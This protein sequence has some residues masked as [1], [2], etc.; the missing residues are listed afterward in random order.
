MANQL[1]WGFIGLQ[2]LFAQRLSTL[3]PRVIDDAITQSLAEWNRQVGALTDVLV[4]RTTEAQERFR[5]PGSGTLQPLDEHGVPIP[6]RVGAF[7]DVGFPIQGGGTAWG[8]NRVSRALMTVGE[9]NELQVMV[10]TQ[11]AD[12]MR[13]HM[14]AALLDNTSWAYSDPDLGAL[15]VHPLANND[16]QQYLLGTNLLTTDDHY[17]AQAAAIST[18]AN[19]FPAIEA[20]LR[21]HPGNTGPYASYI[22]DDLRSAVEGIATFVP[23]SDPD[24]ILG[25]GSDRLA[26]VPAQLRAF[27]DEVIGKVD[28]MWIVT[29][30]AMPSGYILS[31][32]LGAA[33]P[34]LAMR[35]YPDTSLQGLFRE[36][37]RPDSG[38]EQASFIRYAGFAARNRTAGVATFIGNAAYQIPAAFAT[39][40]AA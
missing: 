36:D 9:A 29:Y 26:G 8:T 2:H 25:S 24:I 13:R 3:E 34:A 15:T 38:R 23:V 22:A 1:A 18:A 14:L 19:P 35:E 30:N 33:E 16:T 21:H 7:A 28:G 40:L 5:L 17:T 20:L 37:F 6:V 4:R 31:L 39:P 27:G 11:D 12:W 10:Q 32:A